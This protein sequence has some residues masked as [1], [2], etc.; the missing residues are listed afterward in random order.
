MKVTFKAVAS[1]GWTFDKME[2]LHVSAGQGG[3]LLR[4]PSD[5]AG[6]LTGISGG[7]GGLMGGGGWEVGEYGS[8][9]CLV[10]DWSGDMGDKPAL[11][12]TECWRARPCAKVEVFES[13]LVLLFRLAAVTQRRAV[14]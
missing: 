9:F 3:E 4:R 12:E 6:L 8:G 2:L 7:G 5:E 13:M 14:L 1:R 11:K 10:D